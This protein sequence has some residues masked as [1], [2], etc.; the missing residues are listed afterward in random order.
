MN[1][2]LIGHFR[3]H[4][5]EK[6]FQCRQCANAFSPICDLKWH[7]KRHSEEKPYK[8]RHCVKAFQG[9]VI[10]P[11]I[12]KHIL[13]RNYISEKATPKGQMMACS[14]LWQNLDFF[15]LKQKSKILLNKSEEK[16][17]SVIFSVYCIRITHW[18][19][20]QCIFNLHMLTHTG[21]EPCQCNECDN[22]FGIIF[23]L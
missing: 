11:Y 14:C 12:W 7:L 10:L 6:P 9:K 4:T 19:L 8:F 18:L 5:E 17:I 16:T 3:I 15:L 22:A 21:E 20:F 1:I 23:N 13:Y 2:H